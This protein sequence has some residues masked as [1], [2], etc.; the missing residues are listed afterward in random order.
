MEF[1]FL[2]VQ[3]LGN[4]SSFRSW[5]YDTIFLLSISNHAVPQL[6]AL[7]WQEIIPS[8]SWA[9]VHLNK[10]RLALVLTQWPTLQLT[11]YSKGKWLE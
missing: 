10:L 4:W 2:L 9:N 5:G 3:G 1:N 7:V 6:P 11:L 8:L